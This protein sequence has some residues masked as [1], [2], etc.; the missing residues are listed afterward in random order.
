MGQAL[1]CPRAAG[2]H[3]EE[4]AVPWKEGMQSTMGRMEDS[5]QKHHSLR[6]L[7]TEEINVLQA[8]HSDEVGDATASVRPVTSLSHLWSWNVI[9]F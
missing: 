2:P 5:G 1:S 7:R 4:H 9:P 3:L 8:L 6:T